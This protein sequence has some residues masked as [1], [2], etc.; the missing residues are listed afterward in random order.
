[1]TT[2]TSDDD[3]TQ[4]IAERAERDLVGAV[5]GALPADATNIVSRVDDVD[6]VR[7]THAEI[8]AAIRT[9]LSENPD[10]HSATAVLDVLVRRG[11]RRDV[12]KALLD[13]VSAGSATSVGA[14]RMYATVVVSLAYRR[15]AAGIGM[16]IMDAA[17]T[18]PEDALGAQVDTAVAAFR[19]VSERLAILRGGA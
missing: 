18:A 19:S 5:L 11:A 12:R 15:R 9:A 8:W 3:T 7:W 4:R 10:R 2:L 14:L 17:D 16:A 1:M 13:A 6:F